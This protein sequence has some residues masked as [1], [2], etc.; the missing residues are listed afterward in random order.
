MGSGNASPFGRLETFVQ[1]KNKPHTYFRRGRS[2]K[3]LFPPTRLLVASGVRSYRDSVRH[4][5]SQAGLARNIGRQHAPSHGNHN[6]K[7]AA[8][9]HMLVEPANRPHRRRNGLTDSSHLLGSILR[10][11]ELMGFARRIFCLCG[12]SHSLMG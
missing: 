10:L 9:S 2:Y 7:T 12:A 3:A 1:A 4:P 5:I 11:A 6:N 8:C